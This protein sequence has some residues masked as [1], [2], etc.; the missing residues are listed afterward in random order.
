MTYRTD[1]MIPQQ[2]ESVADVVI[3]RPGDW[4]GREMV[5]GASGVW[6][7]LANPA[8]RTATYYA[9][10]GAIT[11]ARYA[12]TRLSGDPTCG[13]CLRIERVDA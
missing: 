9:I 10:C 3:K 5:A 7:R 12:R 4:S 13:R 6:H 1:P 11:T 8:P 2:A